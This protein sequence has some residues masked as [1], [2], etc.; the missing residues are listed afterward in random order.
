MSE[1]IDLQVEGQLPEWLTGEH[2]TIGPGTYDVRY[3]R[4]IEIDGYLQSATSTF[5]FGHWFDA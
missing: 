3:M 4:K 2:Y 5:S 1:I